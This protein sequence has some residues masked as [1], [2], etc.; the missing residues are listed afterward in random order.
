[1]AEF[2]VGPNTYRSG[3]LDCFDQWNVFR[4]ISPLWQSLFTAIAEARQKGIKLDNLDFAAVASNLRPIADAVA[5]MTDADSDYVMKKCMSV[6]HRQDPSTRTWMPLLAPHGALM[7]QDI[8]MMAMLRVSI[9]TMQENL[10][11][12]FVVFRPQV[13]DPGPPP[14]AG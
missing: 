7:F 2:K 14:P 5:K 9:E 4:R 13:A 6:A 1:M 12:F 10:G 8:D 11:G 3:K